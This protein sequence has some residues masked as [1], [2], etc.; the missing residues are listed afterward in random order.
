MY[1]YITSYQGQQ[2]VIKNLLLRLQVERKSIL[3]QKGTKIL[4]CTKIQ[5]GKEGIS[6]DI[7]K[8]KIG[9]LPESIVLVFGQ[10][11]SFGIRVH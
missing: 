6:F 7:K 8:M 3:V 1:V 10:D 2:K 5:K 9:V 11:G 4:Q